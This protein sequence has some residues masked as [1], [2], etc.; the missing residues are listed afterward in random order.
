LTEGRIYNFRVESRNELGFSAY[1]EVLPILA[2]QIPG[3]PSAPST[4]NLGKNIQIS[5]SP[6]DDG[7]TIITAYT[8]HIRNVDGSDFAIDTTN[9]DGSDP[10]IVADRSCLVPNKDLN[11][12]PHNLLWGDSVYAKFTVTNFYGTSPDS[13][14][15]NGATLVNGPSAPLNFAEDRSLTSGYTIGLTWDEGVDNGGTPVLDYAV[16]GDQATGTWIQ[17]A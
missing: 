9:C 2:A 6:P 12:A 10:T 3:T 14:V 8:I 5:W 17:L 13:P 11:E 7:G 16:W 1:S 4:T 15:G